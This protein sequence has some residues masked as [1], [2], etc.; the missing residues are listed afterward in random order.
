MKRLLMAC[1]VIC[2]LFGASA[3]Q[4][5]YCS[6]RWQGEGIDVA[7]EV[8]FGVTYTAYQDPTEVGCADTYPF[9]VE[10]IIAQFAPLSMDPHGMVLVPM[11]FTADLLEPTCPRPGV[12]LYR[13]DPQVVTIDPMGD[14]LTLLPLGMPVCVNGP[15]FV[16]YEVLD[17]MGPTAIS[18]VIDNGVSLVEPTPR[19]CATYLN[20]YGRWAD[21]VVDAQ[22]PGN[23]ILFSEGHSSP[24]NSCTG[25]AEYIEAGVDLWFSDRDGMLVPPDLFVGDPLPADFFGPGSDPFE[26]Q[27]AL[28][29]RPIYVGPTGALGGADAVIERKNP[30]SLPSVPSA[31]AIEIELVTLSLV[32][33]EPIQVSYMG[34]AYF[35][36]WYVTVC[37][38]PVPTVTPSYME[39]NRECCD[40]GQFLR[41]GGF[42]PRFWF[43]NA[44]Q[45][46]SLPYDYPTSLPFPVGAYWSSDI[47]PPYDVVP[48]SGGHVWIDD[49]CNM[50]ADGSRIPP[51]NKVIFSNLGYPWFAE[52][53]GD[54]CQGI[55]GDANGSGD[56]EPTI[57]DVSIMIDALFITGSCTGLLD[58]LAE[59]DINQSGGP[60]PSC[61]DITIGDVSFLI[62]Y[63][64]IT[65]SAGM[66]LPLCL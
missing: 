45:M 27:I 3:V 35:E 29:P 12:L 30:I 36:L 16:A 62:D 11:V 49:G 6:G 5:D 60:N 54:C 7:Q 64:F 53:C 38:S 19:F 58:C 44:P 41:A 48:I 59:A 22:W 55:V 31:D 66:S 52:P 63:L 23:M 50:M 37:M 15:Y 8:D 40:G 9:A 46:L 20:S 26:G 32:S 18:I 24:Q 1:G 43:H 34:G 33:S 17:I 61:A 28:E 21:L 39:I 57:G 2:L 13:G 47:H 51:S 10:T 14:P 25:C 4:A 56:F 65:G 42:R